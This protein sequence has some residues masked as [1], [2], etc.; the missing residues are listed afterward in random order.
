MADKKQEVE[1]RQEPEKEKICRLD[2][3]IK[4][5]WLR[6]VVDAVFALNAEAKFH[7]KPDGIDVKQV[8]DSHVALISIN[9]KSKVFEEY[10]A[11]SFEIGMDLKKLDALLKL[12]NA[13]DIVE[14]RLD[15]SKEHCLWILFENIKRRIGCIDTAGMSDPNIPN[16]KMDATAKLHADKFQKSLKAAET[17]TD[18]MKITAHNNI[19]NIHSEEDVDF[20]DIKF[21]NGDGGEL[22]DINAPKEQKAMYTIDF[23]KNIIKP[24]SNDTE[25]ELAFSTDK[26]ITVKYSLA[27]NN[28]DFNCMVAPRIESE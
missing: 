15:G 28:I 12:S 11:N 5:R 9:M 24:A 14:L 26:P 23:I 7:V 18:Y 6:T 3:K 13:E 8:D 25:M 20:I 22:I 27:E 4:S 2:A 19:L 16:T 1:K 21:N 10:K 17:V